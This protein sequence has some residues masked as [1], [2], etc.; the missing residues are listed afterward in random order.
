MIPGQKNLPAVI[1]CRLIPKRNSILSSD[2]TTTRI[3]DYAT[4]RLPDFPPR[5]T[6][7][8]PSSIVRKILNPGQGGAGE[9]G[10][11]GER[12]RSPSTKTRI[13]PALKGEAAKKFKLRKEIA[14][15]PPISPCLDFLAASGRAGEP[16]KREEEKGG[17]FSSPFSGNGS[18]AGK[19]DRRP[20]GEKLFSPKQDDMIQNIGPGGGI[21]PSGRRKGRPPYTGP[22]KNS[23]HSGGKTGNHREGMSELKE[24]LKRNPQTGDPQ[25][26]FR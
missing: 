12:Q 4:M 14:P 18:Q 9:S 11:T 16:I 22:S 17:T 10:G 8:F 24:T 23:A 26:G 25:Q 15:G 21:L 2:C 1:F 3:Q 5:L 6:P 13:L 7:F 20:E 19:G